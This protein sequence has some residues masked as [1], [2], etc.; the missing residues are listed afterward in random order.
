[1]CGKGPASHKPCGNEQEND[2]S[3][4]E[5]GMLEKSHPVLESPGNPFGHLSEDLD[6]TEPKASGGAVRTE[7]SCYCPAC[8]AYFLFQLLK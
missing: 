2:G 5:R 1:M 4:W 7:V 8:W 6:L 3:G